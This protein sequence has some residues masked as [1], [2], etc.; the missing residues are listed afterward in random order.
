MKKVFSLRIPTE[1][2]TNIKN[3]AEQK[4]IPIHSIIITILWEHFKN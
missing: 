2:Y 4:G 1:L 3:E